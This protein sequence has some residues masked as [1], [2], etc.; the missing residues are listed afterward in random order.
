MRDL[1]VHTSDSDAGDQSRCDLD[2]SVKDTLESPEDCKTDRTMI[3]W[4]VNMLK[5]R[6][7]AFDYTTFMAV[8][9][10]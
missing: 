6:N 4:V 3:R 9:K 1:I 5:R 10:P 7:R 2:A 8:Q